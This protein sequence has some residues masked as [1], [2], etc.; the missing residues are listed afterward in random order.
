MQPFD[1]DFFRSHV[2]VPEAALL[3]IRE[4]LSNQRKWVGQAVPRSVAFQVLQQS[5]A[6]G[7]AM[8]AEEDGIAGVADQAV[9]QRAK[10]RREE[11]EREEQKEAAEERKR[12]RS[13]RGRSKAGK[14]RDRMPW[15][16]RVDLLDDVPVEFPSSGQDEALSKRAI[17]ATPLKQPR[18]RIR[19][20]DY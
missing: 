3:L 19:L 10:A 4:D 20:G 11:I 8:F 9:R 14:E 17:I 5:A 6:Y 13:S 15:V 18:K 1:V 7:K 16:G 12:Q 2:L